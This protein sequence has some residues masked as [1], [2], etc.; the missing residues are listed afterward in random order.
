MGN[1]ESKAGQREPHEWLRTTVRTRWT[2]DPGDL[3]PPLHHTWGVAWAF[4][5]RFFFFPPSPR[6][7][8]ARAY[9]PG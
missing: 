7:E 5:G 4:W 9:A 6:R 1:G 2:V 8:G 3:L